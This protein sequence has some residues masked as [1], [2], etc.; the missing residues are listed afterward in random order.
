[1]PGYDRETCDGCPY[2]DAQGT[3]V[4][5]QQWEQ[6]L[7]SGSNWQTI[8]TW[9]DMVER[10][11]VQP[12]SS[13]NATRSD[14]TAFYSAKFRGIAYP[15]PSAQLYITTPE[16]VTI[17]G[18]PQAEGLVLNGGTST[19]TVTTQL[20]DAG[21]NPYGAATSS[22][23]APG[24]AV[25]ATTAASLT[26]NTMPAGNFLRA[27]SWTTDA[28]G[29][30]LQTVTSAPILVYNTTDNPTPMLRRLYYSIPAYAQLPGT[31]TL[32]LTGDP[33]VAP[34][35]ATVTA[36]TGTNV[37]FTEVLQ[38]TRQVKQGFTASTFN[39]T[40]PMGSR[41]IIG[42]QVE[43]ASPHGFYV[44]RV[45]DQQERVGYSDPVFIP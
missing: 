12:T 8:S 24:A 3:K 41:S 34:V 19:V 37:R 14:I 5:R 2:Y 36:P 28:N 22:T 18:A 33:S 15:K 43:T 40:V 35:T 13:W 42:Q 1:M 30:V 29:T 25:D 26:V 39:V 38:N 27:K 32:T 45:I 21:G 20:I 23:V 9:N 10:T 7:A 11:E 17:G 6:N 16:Y 4:Y 31:V 44:G